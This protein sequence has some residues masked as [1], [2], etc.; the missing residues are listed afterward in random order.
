ML[1]QMLM[2]PDASPEAVAAKGHQAGPGPT[3]CPALRV[4]RG[5]AG[6]WWAT[7]AT[8]TPTAPRCGPDRWSGWRSPCKPAGAAGH[9]AHRLLAL[10]AGVYAASRQTQPL[11]MS[12]VMALAQIGIAIPNFWFAILL[13]LL[14]SVK[15]QWFSA[16]G[17]PGWTQTGGGRPLGSRRRCC[18][19]P[20][21]W[22]WCRQRSWRAS[23]ARPCWTVRVDFRAHRVPKVLSQRAGTV[24]PCAAQRHDPG[25]HGNGAAVRRCWQAPSWWKTCSTCRAWAG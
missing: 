13:I 9:A 4:G 5:A 18:C 19:R 11:G 14:F 25:G 8:A 21:P 15:L 16:G 3:A 20:L 23:H 12:G 17:F 6:C 1:A 2:G 22:P 10:G 24:G 7:W